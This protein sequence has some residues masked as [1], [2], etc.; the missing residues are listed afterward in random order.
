MLV[1]GEGE[2]VRTVNGSR[3]KIVDR[4]SPPSRQLYLYP[5]LLRG[6][7]VIFSESL[8]YQTFVDQDE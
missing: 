8:I 5:M 2:S 4:R 1:S 3:I 6:R 7:L